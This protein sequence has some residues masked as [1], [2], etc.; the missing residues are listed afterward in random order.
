MV[1]QIK[2]SNGVY[3]DITPYIAFGGLKWSRND[4]DGDSTGRMIEDGNMFR[5]RIATKYRWDI[6][7]R[8]ITASEQALILTLIQPVFVECKYTDPL[9]N[10]VVEDVEYYANNFPST[11]CIARDDGTEIWSGLAFPLIQK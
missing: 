6:T 8:P 9:T 10:T 3:Q 4:V 1:F 5:D 11:F 7:C 2:D